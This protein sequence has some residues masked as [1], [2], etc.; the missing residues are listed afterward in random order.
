[1]AIYVHHPRSAIPSGGKDLFSGPLG[2]NCKR[3]HWVTIQV[4]DGLGSVESACSEICCSA[5]FGDVDTAG[6][7]KLPDTGEALLWE[8]WAQKID[9]ELILE[10]LAIVAEDFDQC[11]VLLEAQRRSLRP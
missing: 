2:D 8:T 1:M 4:N 5:P 3:A 7:S 9:A 11:P 10:P 6:V